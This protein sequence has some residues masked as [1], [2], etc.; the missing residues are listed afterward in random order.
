MQTTCTSTQ[1]IKASQFSMF[2]S[3]FQLIRTAFPE[4]TLNCSET[5]QLLYWLNSIYFNLHFA[6]ALF[7]FSLEFTLTLSDWLQSLFGDFLGKF[8]KT[9]HISES[10]DWASLYCSVEL[11]SWMCKDVE[12]K[13]PVSDWVLSNWAKTVWA[14][15]REIKQQESAKLLV[16]PR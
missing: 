15:R 13:Q 1:Q 8:C 3:F 7:H 11:E 5:L 12:N 10:F 14:V 16:L 4:Q 2:F 9:F 6:M